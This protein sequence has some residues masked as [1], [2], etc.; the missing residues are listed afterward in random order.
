MGVWRTG[1]FPGDDQFDRVAGELK[2]V[3]DKTATHPLL[4]SDDRR[5]PARASGQKTPRKKSKYIITPFTLGGRRIYEEEE[6][7]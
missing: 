7:G 1:D 5:Q 2:K 3:P 6:E 4:R